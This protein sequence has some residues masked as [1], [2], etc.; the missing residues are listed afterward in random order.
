[1]T[2]TVCSRRSSSSSSSLP[3]Q[4]P[5]LIPRGPCCSSSSSLMISK[6]KHFFLPQHHLNSPALPCTSTTSYLFSSGARTTTKKKPILTVTNINSNTPTGGGAGAGASQSQPSYQGRYGPWTI[7]PSDVTEV[8]FS[9]FN[10]PIHH[11]LQSN[12]YVLFAASVPAY[13]T[14][15]CTATFSFNICLQ[16]YN[17]ILF[18]FLMHFFDALIIGLAGGIIQNWVS[19]CCCF[20]CSCI[21][22]NFLTL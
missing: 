17:L 18:F 4:L 3:L 22:C 21:H 19:D 13:L 20:I 8:T 16:T 5:A 15:T 12:I 10:F 1:M 7:Q 2:T 14:N 11:L 6:P 9:A